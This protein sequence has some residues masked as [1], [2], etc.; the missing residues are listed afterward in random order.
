MARIFFMPALQ[1]SRPSQYYCAI[2]RYRNTA[3]ISRNHLRHNYD[4]RYQLSGFEDLLRA[5]PDMTDGLIS[6][7]E[8]LLSILK[9]VPERRKDS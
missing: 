4:K 6:A 8:E 2:C 3:Y 5:R 1:K 9:H 7:F